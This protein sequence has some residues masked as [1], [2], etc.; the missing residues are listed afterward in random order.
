VTASRPWGPLPPATP[1]V[2]PPWPAVEPTHGRVRLRRFDD[3]D[4]P[5]VRELSTDPYVPLIGTLPP[6]CD[7]AGAMAYIERQRGRHTEGTGFSFVISDASSGHALGMIGLWL[8]DYAHGRAQ[9]GYAVAPGAR[10]RS[11][12]SDA[13]HALSSFA[14]TLPGLHRLELHVEPWNVASASVA[15]RA[16]FAYEGLL[17]GYLEIGGLRRDLE[18]YA[19]IRT[20][21]PE[22]VTPPVD[23]MRTVMTEGLPTSDP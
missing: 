23:G 6:F 17:R 20:A 5:M 21:V 14:W 12:A 22:T 15:R 19:L 13:L 2:L 7:E 4:I 1:P 16:G 11:A 8:R 3:A 18:S 10:R 9:A